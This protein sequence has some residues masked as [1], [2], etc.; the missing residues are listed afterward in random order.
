MTTGSDNRYEK[1]KVIGVGG[2]GV[3]AVNRMI[4]AGMSSVEFVAINTD[5]KALDLSLCPNK[6]QLGPNLTNGLGTGGNPEE[7]KA[8]AEESK[9]EIKRLLEG[10]DM[11]FIAAGMGGGTGTGA[12]PVVA[13]L[14]R[15]LGILTVA[16]VTRPFSFEGPKRAGVADQGI[17]QLRYNVD[18][19]IIIPNERLLSAVEKRATFMEAFRKADDVLRMGVQ[20][21]SDIIVVPGMVNVDFKDVRTIMADQ[22]TALMGI[23]IASGENRHLEAAELACKSQLLEQTIDGARGVLVNIAAGLDLRLDEVHEAADFVY[24]ACDTDN[25]NFIFGA[26]IDPDMGDE[27]KITVV[28]TGFREKD[29]FES[30]ETLMELSAR[31]RNVGPLTGVDVKKEEEDPRSLLDVPAFI[32]NGNQRQHPL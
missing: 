11:V 17:S 28:A 24:K 13:E 8:A 1:I 6:L 10:S 25:V 27:I 18:T 20:G 2:G 4:E 12:A 16:V 22:G 30:S 14:S 3:N 21:I 29:T 9:P 19:L 32:R 23:G 15:E 31:G 7:G 26:V 5:Y